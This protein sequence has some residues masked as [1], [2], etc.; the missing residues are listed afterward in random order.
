MHRN[1]RLIFM[2]LVQLKGYA[3]RKPMQ[4]IATCVRQT[5]ALGIAIGPELAFAG[6]GW[7]QQRRAR[8]PSRSGF[9]RSLASSRP[10]C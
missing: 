2:K 5:T 3:Y 10:A 4:R 1:T 7:T 6:G 8:P 9:I